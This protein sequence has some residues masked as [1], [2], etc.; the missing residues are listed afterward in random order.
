MAT[1]PF[2][3]CETGNTARRDN[4]SSRGSAISGRKT[5]LALAKRPVRKVPIP[6]ELVRKGRFDEIFFVDLPGAAERREIFRV[7]LLKKNRKPE[8]FDLEALAAAS[9][10]FSGAEIEQAVKGALYTAYAAHQDLSTAHILSELKATVPLSVTRREDIEALR[11]WARGR[12][13]R[14]N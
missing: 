8:G 13:V 10:G 11:Q 6:P 12:A 1:S 3:F 2:N 9:E 7:H 4:C 5:S 14:A